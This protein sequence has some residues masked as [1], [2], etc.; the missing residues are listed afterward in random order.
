MFEFEGNGQLKINM[1]L[2]MINEAIVVLTTSHR[3]GELSDDAN[4]YVVQELL[5][6]RKKVSNPE[7]QK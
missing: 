2:A 4:C 6:L 5:E 1:M 3:N 7:N